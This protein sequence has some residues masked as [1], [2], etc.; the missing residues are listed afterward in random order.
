M[1][2]LKDKNAIVCGSTQGIGRAIAE[3]FAEL[4]ASVTLVARNEEKLQL[5]KKGLKQSDNQQHDYIVADF[6]D[7]DTLKEK[8]ESYVSSNPPVHIL[9]NNSGGPA[10]GLLID[11]K[12]EEFYQAY[13]MHL[14]CNHILVQ[15]LTEGMKSEN[16]GR[17]INIISTSVKQPIPG[18]GVSNTTRGAVGSWAKTLAGELGPYA[19][20]VNN[21]LPGSTDTQRLRSIFAVRAEKNNTTPEEETEKNRLTIPLRRFADPRETAYAAAFLASPAGAY[22]TGINLPVDGGRTSSL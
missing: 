1:F 14:I 9:V 7:P 20:T 4:E 10:G 16:Y 6:S 5:V 12:I 17:I 18:L 2:N 13:N 22:V 19:I 8:I 15:S 21:I 3:V 11:A